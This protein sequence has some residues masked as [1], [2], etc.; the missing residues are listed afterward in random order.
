MGVSMIEM[1]KIKLTELLKKKGYIDKPYRE[2]SEEIGVDHVSLWKMIKGEKYNPSL[3]TLDKLC[4]FFGC[5]PGD[6]LEH[7]RG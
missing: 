3:E 5:Q 6:L 2:M 7:K 1:I 4:D